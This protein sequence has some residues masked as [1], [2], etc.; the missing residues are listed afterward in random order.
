MK[1]KCG[2]GICLDD[3]CQNSIISSVYHVRIYEDDGVYLFGTMM[4]S[5]IQTVTTVPF[6]QVCKFRINERAS[7]IR[8]PRETDRK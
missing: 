4:S 7:N 2:A 3:D 8:E 6:P 5:V 1:I